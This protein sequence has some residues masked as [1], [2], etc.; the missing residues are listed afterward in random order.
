MARLPKF[1]RGASGESGD[2]NLLAIAGV[3]VA[4]VVGML[5]LTGQG[6]FGGGSAAEEP[7]PIPADPAGAAAASAAPGAPDAKQTAKKTDRQAP[8]NAKPKGKATGA[9]STQD[10]KPSQPKKPSTDK[11]GAAPTGGGGDI[12]DRYLDCMAKA[13]GKKEIDRCASIVGG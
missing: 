11:A 2:S 10:K 9:G 4:A 6:P 3:G 12:T 13:Q 7:A 5:V 1:E 8:A